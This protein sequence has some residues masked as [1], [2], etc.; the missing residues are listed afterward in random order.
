MRDACIIF[1]LLLNYKSVFLPGAEIKEIASKLKDII[2]LKE[3]SIS[4]TTETT[5]GKPVVDEIEGEKKAA[6]P[7][8]ASAA[9]EKI[10]NLIA[11]IKEEQ[12]AQTEKAEEELMQEITGLIIE[13]TMTK[14]GYEFY[15]Y[16][17]LQWKPPQTELKNYNILI[18]EKASPMWGSLV[19]VKIGETI[20][21][22][23][24]LRPRSEEIEESAQQALEATKEYLQ[25]Y[26]KY[27]IKTIDLMGNG[28]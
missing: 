21:W 20:V 1:V 4:T 9:E 7:D 10:I 17:F 11:E 26:E 6:K 18:S 12:A 2:R 15:E 28:I 3:T 14:I 24:M 16:F 13:E 27:Q 19:E 22:S 23:R 25:N 8:K 5:E